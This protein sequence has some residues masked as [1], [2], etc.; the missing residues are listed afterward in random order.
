[1][2]DVQFVEAMAVASALNTLS[3]IVGIVINDAKLRSL[4]AEVGNLVRDRDGRFGAVNSR[5]NEIDA[6]FDE[7]REICITD[8]RRFEKTI[9]DRVDRLE[10]RR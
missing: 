6:R 8:L 4:S 1:M 10:Q 2:T 7:M 5:F 9:L 3:V